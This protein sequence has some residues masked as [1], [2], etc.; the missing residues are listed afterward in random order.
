MSFCVYIYGN[1][2]QIL[3]HLIETNICQRGIGN[4]NPVK[5]GRY[6]KEL[7][8]IYGVEHGG[9][10]KSNPKVSEMNQENIA[11]MSKKN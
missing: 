4:P 5:L 6:I 8:R 10:R 9:N 1:I 7:E 11:E 3:A 2:S